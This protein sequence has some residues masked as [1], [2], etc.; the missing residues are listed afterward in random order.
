MFYS[1]LNLKNLELLSQVSQKKGADF[2]TNKMSRSPLISIRKFPIN[3][4]TCNDETC[5]DET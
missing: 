3:D 2:K 5:N 1:A 4:E